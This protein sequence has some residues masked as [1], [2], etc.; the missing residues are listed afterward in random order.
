MLAGAISAVTL[1]KHYDNKMILR[2]PIRPTVVKGL[3]AT[4]SEIEALQFEKSILSHSITAIYEAIQK[5][6][7]GAVEHDRLLLKYKSQ[8]DNFNKKIG[9]LQLSIDLTELSEMRTQLVYLLEERIASIDVRLAE[10]SKKLEIPLD[11]V[12][13]S[14]KQKHATEAYSHEHSEIDKRKREAKREAVSV[15]VEKKNIQEIE[16]Q[17]MQA[18]DNLEHAGEV[19]YDIEKMASDQKLTED[20]SSQINADVLSHTRNKSRDALSFLSEAEIED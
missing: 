5:G 8:L 16:Q 2:K 17:I 4:R 3:N 20:G 10:I 6:K 9:E 15:G 7:I 14:T 13:H 12:F 18:L 1:W 19:E 11:P